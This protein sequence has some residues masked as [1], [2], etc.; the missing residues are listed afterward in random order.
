MLSVV[1]GCGV[2]AVRWHILRQRRHRA[3]E[4]QVPRSPANRPC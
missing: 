2:S 4:P 3:W 1:G